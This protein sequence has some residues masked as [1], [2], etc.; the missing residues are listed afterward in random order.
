MSGYIRIC[1]SYKQSDK[2]QNHSMMQSWLPV[3]MTSLVAQ[4]IENPPEMQQTW[5]WP[6]DWEDFPETG[7]AT[8]SRILASRILGIYSPW[9]HKE[10][11]MTEQLSLTSSHNYYIHHFFKLIYDKQKTQTVLGVPTSNNER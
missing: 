5:V 1:C 11:N 9:G 7:K 3:H 10:S 8:H 2:D 6:L 4:M